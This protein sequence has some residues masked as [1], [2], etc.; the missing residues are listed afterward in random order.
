MMKINIEEWRTVAEYEGL[1]EVS[2]FGR[3]RR[4]AGTYHCNKNRILSACP[5]CK[6][7]HLVVNLS[8]DCKARTRLVHRLVAFAFL[9]NP[10]EEKMEVAHY[11]GD[12]TNNHVSNLRWTSHKDNERDKI[13]HDRLRKGER[14]HNASLTEI[15][16]LEIRKLVAE[17]EN[18][19]SVAKKFGI[20]QPHVSEIHLRL[21]WTWL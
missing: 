4:L 2:S 12:S 11:D 19:Y 17:G 9:G 5:C 8:K 1:Y 14:H 7:G 3:V 13:R 21:S 10:P 6:W 16:V 20:S 15:Q 18:Q